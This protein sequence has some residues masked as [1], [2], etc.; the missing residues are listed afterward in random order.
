VSRRRRLGGVEELPVPAGWV[1][2]YLALL[3]L[4]REAASLAALT[5]LVRAQSQSVVF[6][7]VTAILRRVRTG[8]GPV[9][10]PDPEELLDN[11]AA[12]R[13]GGVCFDLAPTFRRLLAGLGYPV[14]PILAQISFPGSHHA[15][16]V[17]LHGA[18][19]LVDV[20]GGAPLWQP[21]RL[22]DTVEIRHAALGYRLR[23]DE[24]RSH[25]QD[26]ALDGAWQPHCRYDLRPTDAAARDAAYQ[27]HQL[28]GETWVVGNLTMVRCTP[29]AIHRLRDDELVSYTPAGKRV[30]RLVDPADYERVAAELFG[31]PDLPVRAALAALDEIRRVRV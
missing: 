7:N 28:A 25:A 5:R 27:R 23:P 26:R 12:R 11:W 31:L 13:G 17:D 8:E 3:G 15:T 10:P 14:R 4:E 6:E 24:P 19:Y 21:F 9:P 16:L 18:T 20:G 29:E 22:D 1:D 30:E 2:R